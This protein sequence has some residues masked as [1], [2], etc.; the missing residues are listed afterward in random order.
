MG[1]PEDYTG[2]TGMEEPLDAA[3][4]LELEPSIEFKDEPCLEPQVSKPRMNWLFIAADGAVAA[5]VFAGVF[6]RDWIY[7][8]FTGAQ[9]QKQPQDSHT[10]G[11]WCN[12]RTILGNLVP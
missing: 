6:C 12:K 3:A 5:L 2:P 11:T 7:S 10:L 1:E 9:D 8:L 4:N